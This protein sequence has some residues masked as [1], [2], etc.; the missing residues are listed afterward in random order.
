MRFTFHG[1]TFTVHTEAELL[2]LIERL[3]ARVAA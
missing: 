1:V 2:S 3:Q